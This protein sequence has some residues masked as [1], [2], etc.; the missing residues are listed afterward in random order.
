MAEQVGFIGGGNMARSLVGGLLRGGQSP[1]N[2]LVAE[3][4]AALRRGLENDFS[5]Q[6]TDNNLEL[7]SKVKTL[8]FAVKP[9][10]ME[11]V[12]T[13][14]SSSASPAEQLVITIAAGIR[15]ADLNS[16]LGGSCAIVRAMP[17]T[18]ALV[19]EGVT[20]L[21]A[22]ERVS[23]QQRQDAE[24]ILGCVGEVVWFDREEALDAVTAVSGSGPA[25][26][27]L[28]MEVLEKTGVELG[29]TKEQARKLAVQTA[30]GAAELAKQSDLDLS[31]LR[32]NVTSPGGTT[33]AAINHLLSG[34]F[35][36]LFSEA[37]RAAAARSV[38]LS[39]Q[40]G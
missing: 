8:V 39:R 2:I 16:W 26:F 33:E 14:L 37:I 27:F 19:G 4:V 7:R 32:K 20:G 13:R 9:Q 18:P 10:V 38:E 31:E 30:V 11:E 28:F 35:E 24:Q 17:N 34:D 6:V 36:S 1:L 29:L 25:Y 3:P 5:I 23:E 21:Y 22:N 12:A 40:K 15:E